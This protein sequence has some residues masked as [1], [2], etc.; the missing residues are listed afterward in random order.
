MTTAMNSPLQPSEWHYNTVFASSPLPTPNPCFIEFGRTT[1]MGAAAVGGAGG[2]PCVGGA[3]GAPG[4]TGAGG[5]SGGAT[6]GIIGSGGSAAGAGGA[7]GGVGIPTYSALFQNREIR[8]VLTNLETIVGDP[9]QIR[10]T[11]DGGTV[12]QVVPV[13]VD[14][15]VGLPA[16]IKLGPVP[17]TDQTLE[18]AVPDPSLMVLP[19]DLPYL[20]VV[21][22]RNSTTGRAATRGQLLRITPRQSDTSPVPAYQSAVDSNSYFPIQ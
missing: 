22:Q 13:A 7:S 10:F 8:F 20:F 2:G 9:V 1:P 16:R 3:G 12:A 15:A 21:D 19:S 14:S 18:F 11:V 17:S 4:A 5:D 6:G